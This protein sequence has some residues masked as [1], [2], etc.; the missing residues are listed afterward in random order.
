MKKQIKIEYCGGWGYSGAAFSLKRSIETV[1]PD[2][3]ITT[4]PEYGGES[5]RI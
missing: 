3:E 2:A 1:W 5:S 4:K